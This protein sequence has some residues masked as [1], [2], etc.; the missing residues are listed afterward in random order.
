MYSIGSNPSLKRKKV[1][2][3]TKVFLR[4]SFMGIGFDLEKMRTDRIIPMNP[5]HS[6]IEVE[7]VMVR[8]S[9]LNI[10]IYNIYIYIY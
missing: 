4:P 7:G 9:Q 3:D 8:T 1:F 5:R 10:Y 6:S 2:L